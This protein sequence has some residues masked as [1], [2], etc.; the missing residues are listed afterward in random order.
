[1][2]HRELLEL[3]ERAAA[4][5]SGA[6]IRPGDV[7]CWQTPNWWE[8]HLLGLAV[9]HVGA[10]SAPIAPFY[11]EHELRQVIEEVRPA[12][13]ISAESFRGFEHAEAFDDLLAENGLDEIPRILLRGS[14]FGWT[15]FDDVVWH[16]IDAYRPPKSER[17]SLAWSCSPPAPRRAPRPPCTPRARCWP[18]PGNSLTLGGCAGRMSPTWPRR[19]NTSPDC[20]MQ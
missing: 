4:W 11:R 5:L 9:W 13:V 7:V 17:T 8:A 6:G 3:V 16:G 18:K 1:M 15:P 10:V 20:S 14:R 19:C 2:T 12:A